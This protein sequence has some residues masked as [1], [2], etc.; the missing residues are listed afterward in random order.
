M[1]F[2][3]SAIALAYDP[4]TPH[5]HNGILNPFTT[6]PDSVSISA[7]EQSNLDA[8]NVVLQTI[9]DESTGVG[10]GVAVQYV[11]ATETTVWSTILNYPKYTDWVDNVVESSVYKTEKSGKT[12]IWHVELIS[13]MMF[14]KFGVY[15]INYI[16]K[17]ENYMH[18]TLDYERK[19]D[20][21]D[22]VGYWRVEQI[23]DN[24]IIT[25][26]DYAT[27]MSVKGVPDFFA[28]YL[29]KDALI[30][31][32]KWVKREAEKAQK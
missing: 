7:K 3:L 30:N 23:S 28:D 24:P 18:W 4:G 19:S 5:G 26:V 1:I 20:A 2:L 31:G 11:E 32:T 27:Q 6:A 13:S 9:L 21:H 15:T 8:G 22:L 14:V 12:D 25:R 17:P 16:N 29:T 10:R